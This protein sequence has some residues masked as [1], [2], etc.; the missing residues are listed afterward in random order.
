MAETIQASRS[1]ACQTQARESKRN[2]HQREKQKASQTIKRDD[3]ETKEKQTDGENRGK[4]IAKK[5][6]PY[7]F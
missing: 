2:P 1:L 4:A 7:P 3:R 5:A 6:Q